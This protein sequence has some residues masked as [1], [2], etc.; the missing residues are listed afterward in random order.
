MIAYWIAVTLA[1]SSPQTI[2]L[3]LPGFSNVNIDDKAGDLYADFFAQ[4]LVEQGNLRVVTKN[5]VGALLGFDRQK[6][7]LGCAESTCLAELAG[8]MGVDGVVA[9]SLGKV[10]RSYV[11]NV[12]VVA[13]SDA[14][15]LVS[16]SGRVADEEALLDWLAKT[17]ASFVP[18][19]RQGLGRSAPPVPV[20]VMPE[21][22]APIV[23]ARAEAPSSLRSSAWIP[24]AAGGAALVAGG[25]VYAL[26]AQKVGAVSAGQG[27]YATP[28]ALDADLDGAKGMQT[29]GFVLGGIGVAAAA[30]GGAM[31][32][33]GGPS[34]GVAV[35]PSG[36]GVIV[37]GAWR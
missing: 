2:K 37:K 10:G 23:T 20:A 9:G 17:A 7:L 5:E 22:P 16:A 26:A 15:L 32:L 11:V 13:A 18:Q 14:R 3:A 25:V 27:S 24:V 8:A 1:A 19:I 4:R 34:E 29:L 6:Q 35:I 33:W 21:K 12:K 36:A 28:V 30:A 31:Y